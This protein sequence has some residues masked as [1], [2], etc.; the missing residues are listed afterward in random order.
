VA[1]AGAGVGAWLGRVGTADGDWLGV[2]EMCGVGVLLGCRDGDADG[3]GL[4]DRVGPVPEPVG[5]AV[6]VA[7]GFGVGWVLA[8]E[9]GFT[10]M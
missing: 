9:S 4:A 7:V 3:E 2:A 6:G 10:H 8:V 1:G 5:V